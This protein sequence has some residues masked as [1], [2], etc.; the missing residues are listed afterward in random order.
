MEIHISGNYTELDFYKFGTSYM[1]IF[2][3]YAHSK[4]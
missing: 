1:M 3:S 2:M 4:K